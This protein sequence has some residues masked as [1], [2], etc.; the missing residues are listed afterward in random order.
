MDIDYLLTLQDFREGVLSG[1]LNNLGE[2]MS[3]FITGPWF[4]MFFAIVF[5]NFNKKV[6]FSFFATL[7]IARFLGDTL[8]VFVCCYRP[9]IRDPRIVPAGDAINKSTGYSFPSGHSVFSVCTYGTLAVWMAKIKKHWISIIAIVLGL[10]T[11]FSRNFLGVHTPQDVIAGTTVGLLCLWLVPKLLNILEKTKQKTDFLVLIGSILFIAIIIA[12]VLNKPYPMDYVDDKIIVDPIK[13]QKDCIS[14]CGYL[15][16]FALGWFIEKH[17][18]K[19]APLKNKWIGFA[20]SVVLAIPIY[21]I[22][23]YGT[24][25]LAGFMDMTVAI[26]IGGFIYYAY[27]LILVPL[28]IKVL[29]GKIN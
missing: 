1:S 3:N 22:N 26:F 7:G 29:Y 27:I 14:S 6:G 28:I 16:A 8:K 10:A 18:I 24:S 5:W 15:V 17:F 9:W 21:L 20:V 4:F 25:L 13:M 2:F 19:F 11:I 23:Q 12:V